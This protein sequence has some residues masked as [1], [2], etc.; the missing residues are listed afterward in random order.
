MSPA[1]R[2]QKR[3]RAAF[4]EWRSRLYL[5]EGPAKTEGQMKREAAAFALETVKLGSEREL[6]EAEACALVAELVEKLSPNV[7]GRLLSRLESIHR[8]AGERAK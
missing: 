5:R 6:T 8:R 4:A 7:R 3:E 1:D 2:E